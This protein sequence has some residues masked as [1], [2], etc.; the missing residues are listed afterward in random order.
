MKKPIFFLMAMS[1]LGQVPAVV[2]GSVTM[3]LI[4]H[5]S[6]RVKWQAVPPSSTVGVWNFWRLRTIASPGTCENGTG[7]YVSTGDGSNKLQNYS[8]VAG[9]LLPSTTYDVC[10]EGS[11]DGQNWSSGVGGTF[12]T[13][14]LPAAHPV[15]P[16]PPKRFNTDYPD[17]TGYTVVNVPSNDDCSGLENAINAAIPNLNTTGTIINLPAGSVCTGKLRPSALAPDVV[18]LNSPAFNVSAHTITSPN[19]GFNEG[20]QIVWSK[21]P[22]N[23]SYPGGIPGQNPNDATQGPIIIGHLYWVHV[24]DKDTFQVYYGAPYGATCQDETY[25]GNTCPHL[26]SFTD[27]GSGNILYAPW[28]RKLKWVIVRTSTPDAQFVPEHVRVNPNW[29]PL[30]AK[31]QAP[32]S[33][34]G[35]V[36]TPNIMFNTAGGDGGDGANQFL[37]ANLRF[38]GIEFT[39][40][41][42]PQAATTADPPPGVQLIQISTES[43]NIIFDRC[44]IHGYPTPFRVYRML[45]WDGMNVGIVDS[46]IR[47][48]HLFR[49]NSVGLNTHQ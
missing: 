31:I 36:Y 2:P 39:Y 6:A 13:A 11:S 9:G 12:T 40:Q 37:I 17:T 5:S 49:A 14:P 47:D 24:I 33:L 16:I 38:V 42:Y 48:M 21:Q 15:S 43:Q 32:N 20:D 34:L 28:P 4:S 1:A 8:T 35:A 29:A 22:G 23:G 10:P 3:D 27:Q 25:E 26:W 45:N 7:G 18:V 19:H 46:D 30:M 41:P 44:Y